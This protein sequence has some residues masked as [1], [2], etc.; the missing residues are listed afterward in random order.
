MWPFKRKPAPPPDYR[1]WNED[2]RIGDTAEVVIT[3]WSDSVLPWERLP[4]GSR[5]TVT[6]FDDCLST[7]R[8]ARFYFLYIKG[9]KRGYNTQCFRKVRTVSADQSEIV[10][11]ILKAKPAPDKTRSPVDT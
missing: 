8:A 1:D 6:G 5:W 2:W 4:L 3:E 7:D 10:Q 11:R 9:F